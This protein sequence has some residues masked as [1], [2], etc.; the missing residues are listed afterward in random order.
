MATEKKVFDPAYEATKAAYG[1]AFMLAAME[2]PHLKA[3]SKEILALQTKAQDSLAATLGDKARTLSADE[4]A[5]I[6]TSK[7]AT[8]IR[9]MALNKW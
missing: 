3:F 6:A 4:K 8:V 5:A 9:N 1:T 2:N 7:T